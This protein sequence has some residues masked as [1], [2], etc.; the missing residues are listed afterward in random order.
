MIPT[1]ASRHFRPFLVL[2]I[3]IKYHEQNPTSVVTLL[4]RDTSL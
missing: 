3:Q 4:D 2:K 1:F